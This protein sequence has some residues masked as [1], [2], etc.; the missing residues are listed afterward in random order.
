MKEEKEEKKKKKK[1][2]KKQTRSSNGLLNILRRERYFAIINGSISPDLGRFQ[3]AFG[4]DG[5]KIWRVAANML[6]IKII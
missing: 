2:K 6:D 4:G 3:V 1:K 5:L